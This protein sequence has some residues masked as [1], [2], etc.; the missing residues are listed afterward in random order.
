VVTSTQTMTVPGRR[1][2]LA[3]AVATMMAMLVTAPAASAQ[4]NGLESEPTTSDRVSGPTRFDTA[5]ELALDGY[6]EAGAPVAILATGLDFPDALAANYLAGQ[7]DDA[8]GGPILLTAPRSVPQVTLAALERLGVE[9]VLLMGGTG[10]VSTA[11]ERQLEAD[12]DVERIAGSSRFETAAAVATS[13]DEVGELNGLR[14]ALLATGVNWPDAMVGGSLAFAGELPLLL[15]PQAGLHPATAEALEDLQ[16]EQVVI[17]GGDGV[18]A[19]AVEAQLA[20]AGYTTRR[21]NGANRTATAAEVARL[22]VDELGFDLTRVNIATGATFPDALTGGPNAG[23]VFFASPVL[24]TDSADSLGAEATA[25]LEENCAFVAAI[26]VFGGTAAVSQ[27]A[28]DAAQAAA[29]SCPFS[30]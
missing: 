13:G 2:A 16:I 7:L 8:Q 22:A 24:L 1:I 12:Y 30:L 15:T 6:G 14:T 26:R 11:V 10:A 9:R 25:F 20:D 19:P 21:V 5:A 3:A 27:A 17:L 29:A 28:A 4:V 23:R 18:V